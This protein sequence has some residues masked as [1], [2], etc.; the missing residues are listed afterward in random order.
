VKRETVREDD[1]LNY[2]HITD[3]IFRLW[4]FL[5]LLSFE[6]VGVECEVSVSVFLGNAVSSRLQHL[7][8]NLS[9]EISFAY[10]SSYL[11]PKTHPILY[12]FEVSLPSPQSCLFKHSNALLS[13]DRAES[14]ELQ[15][16]LMLLS[17]PFGLTPNS[18]ESANY[19]Y[20][21]SRLP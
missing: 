9:H 18:C 4:D 5:S 3:T 13:L 19:F 21:L 14:K 10:T 2:S 16:K 11:K 15:S 12:Y 6:D 1:K 7:S 17:L 8:S 20:T